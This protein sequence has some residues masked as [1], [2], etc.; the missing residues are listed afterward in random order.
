MTSIFEC[1]PEPQMSQ[2]HSVKA[3]ATERIGFGPLA[4]YVIVGDGEVANEFP[5]SPKFLG[6]GDGQQ[7]PQILIL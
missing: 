3:L 1:E 6:R 7:F 5:L 2:T 4:F